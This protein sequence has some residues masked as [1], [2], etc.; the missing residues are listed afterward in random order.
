[1]M[2]LLVLGPMLLLEYRD[3]HAERLDLPCAVLLTAAREAF[4]SG[5]YITAAIQ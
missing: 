3:T 4:T 1:M 5:I 2:L